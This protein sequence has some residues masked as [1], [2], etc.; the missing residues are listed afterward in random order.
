[1][2]RPRFIHRV[3]RRADVQKRGASVGDRVKAAD[4]PAAHRNGLSVHDAGAVPR[5]AKRPEAHRA[6]AF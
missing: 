6:D 4:R 3:R 1:M 2:H 5:H